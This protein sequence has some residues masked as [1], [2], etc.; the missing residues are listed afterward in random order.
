[1]AKQT[2]RDFLG[3]KFNL[4]PKSRKLYIYFVRE[5]TDS[6]RIWWTSMGTTIEVDGLKFEVIK[7]I[8]SL[9]E[10]G[11]EGDRRFFKF[12]NDHGFEK[13]PE[14]ALDKYVGI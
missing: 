10:E 6:D 1:M 7:E 8:P 11:K 5:E 13:V 9:T 2:L 4:E 12:L 14:E 3:E